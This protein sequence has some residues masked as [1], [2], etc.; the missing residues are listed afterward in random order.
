MFKKV[1]I[2]AE[3]L[4]I[5]FPP[6]SPWFWGLIVRKKKGESSQCINRFMSPYERTYAHTPTHTQ[7]CCLTFHT[8]VNGLHL[9][10]PF[11]SS[12][13]QRI[14]HQWSDLLPFLITLHV[15]FILYKSQDC[16]ISTLTNIRRLKFSTSGRGDVQYWILLCLWVRVDWKHS[17]STSDLAL[18][19]FFAVFHI[20][21]IIYYYCLISLIS[22]TLSKFLNNGLTCQNTEEKEGGDK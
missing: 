18:K 5:C 12:S 9:S 14:L 21:I 11:L 10:C 3:L 22:R 1:K 19:T 8:V 15:C 17:L 6:I 7:P 16:I 20:I 13:F 4:P 2:F